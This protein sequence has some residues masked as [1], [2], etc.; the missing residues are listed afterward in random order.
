MPPLKSIDLFSGC[1]GITLALSGIAEPLMYCDIDPVARRALNHAMDIGALPRAPISEDVKELARKCPKADIVVGGSPCTGMSTFGLLQGFDNPGSNLFYEM[2]KVV[3]KSGAKAVF[4]ENVP[5]ML[6][7]I[8]AVIDELSVKR[9][10]QL[11]WECVSARAV[12]APHERNRWFCLAVKNG[13]KLKKMS[14][15]LLGKAYAAYDWSGNG[16]QRTTSSAKTQSDKAFHRECWGLMGNSVVPDAVRLAF[17]RL[18]SGGQCPSLDKDMVLKFCPC[19]NKGTSA[20]L[21]CNN[22]ISV[23][24]AGDAKHFEYDTKTPLTRKNVDRKLVFDPKVIR[25]PT[26]KSPMQTTATLKV[27]VVYKQWATP[28]HGQVG[29]CRVLTERSVK[30]LPTQVRFERGTKNRNGTLSGDFV[31]WM[32]GYPIG[33]TGRQR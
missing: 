20:P 18:F 32:M 23:V 12:G 6:M 19:E 15:S 25:A 21:S 1:G 5:G 14:I 26:E 13:S 9:G 4:I 31:E 22:G 16:P 30:D 3:D 27:P 11:R 28:R 8:E 33:W 7:E 17:C 29:S 10:F 2:M 24:P